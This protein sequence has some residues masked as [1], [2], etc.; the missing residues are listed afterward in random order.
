MTKKKKH[1]LW[2]LDQNSKGGGSHKGESMGGT[3]MKNG[4]KA[5]H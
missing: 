1:E 5:Y 4:V 2:G 3:R